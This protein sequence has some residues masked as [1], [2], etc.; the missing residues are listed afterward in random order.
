MGIALNPG[1]GPS[2]IT[3][4]T[5]I[6]CLTKHSANENFYCYFMKH[7]ATTFLKVLWTS[8]LISPFVRTNSLKLKKI[9]K[10]NLSWDIFCNVNTD[11]SKI[12]LLYQSKMSRTQTV[13]SGHDL[14][15]DTRRLR[16]APDECE[17]RVAGRAILISPI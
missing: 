13:L 4:W 5:L 2:L 15:I 1:L 7:I 6:K 12:R 3:V 14:E 9:W 8:Y 11:A 16:G 10:I 17:E